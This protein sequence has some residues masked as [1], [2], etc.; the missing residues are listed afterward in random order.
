M[1]TYLK[2]YFGTNI[3]NFN[4]CYNVKM[5]SYNNLLIALKNAIESDK[6]QLIPNILTPP[7]TV[8]KEAHHTSLK[9]SKIVNFYNNSDMTQSL[10]EKFVNFN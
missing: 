7:P 10:Y 3:H 4:E 6:R 2:D 5:Q 8:K 9:K 1:D